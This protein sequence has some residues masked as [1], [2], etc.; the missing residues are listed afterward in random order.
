MHHKKLAIIIIVLIFMLIVGIGGYIYLKNKLSRDYRFLGFVH[1]PEAMIVLEG[2]RS[3]ALHHFGKIYGQFREE[4]NEEW[5]RRIKPLIEAGW[6]PTDTD[7]ED[8]AYLESLGYRPP[9]INWETSPEIIHKLAAFISERGRAQSTVVD[10]MQARLE[11]N[12]DKVS[13]FLTDNA[14]QQYLQP[15]LSLFGA[16]NP[17]FQEF[18]ILENDQL[19]SAQ[20]NI[21]VRIYEEYT[22]KG[23]VG[24]FDENLIVKKIGDR[25]LIDGVERCKYVNL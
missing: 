8:I 16:S 21:K 22:G 1:F 11:K 4:N 5:F 7:T 3:E 9:P 10:F 24:Y 6:W 12:M 17:H 14:K 13:I 18:E 2:I 19:D 23:S 15:G 25:Y 20:F